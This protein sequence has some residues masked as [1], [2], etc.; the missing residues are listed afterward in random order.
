V[1][2]SLTLALSIVAIGSPSVQTDQWCW[3]ISG[4]EAEIKTLELISERFRFLAEVLH[5]FC[6]PRYAHAKQAQGVCHRLEAGARNHR[7][8]RLTRVFKIPEE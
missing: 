6:A 5:G 4:I 8:Q 3:F 1:S 7:A 2:V